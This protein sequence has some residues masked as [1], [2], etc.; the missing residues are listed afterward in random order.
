M[1]NNMSII[2]AT[3]VIIFVAIT[4]LQQYYQT[5]QAFPCIGH[6]AKEYCTGYHDGAVQATRDYK[7]ANDLHQHECTDSDLYCNGYSRGYNDQADF[8]G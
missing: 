3:A 5:A 7:I 2:L 6:N 4:I 1:K 8:L